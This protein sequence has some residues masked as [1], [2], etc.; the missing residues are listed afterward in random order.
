MKVSTDRYSSTT[1]AHGQKGGHYPRL[2]LESRS[3]TNKYLNLRSLTG[4]EGGP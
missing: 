4:K 2:K 3:V 1:S